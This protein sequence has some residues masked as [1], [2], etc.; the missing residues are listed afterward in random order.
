MTCKRRDNE[1]D[2]VIDSDST[3]DGNPVGIA[4]R[5]DFNRIGRATEE[6]HIAGRGQG[7]DRI[8]GRQRAPGSDSQPADGAG[9]TKR[10]AAADGNG[11]RQRAVDAELAR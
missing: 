4:G 1:F 5:V 2:V 8:A 11:A 10:R 6:S 3:G 9:T 7:A